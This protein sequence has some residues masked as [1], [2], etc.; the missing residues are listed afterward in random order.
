MSDTI[1]GYFLKILRFLRNYLTFSEFCGMMSLLR[2]KGE[3]IMNSRF[4]DEQIKVYAGCFGEEDAIYINNKWHEVLRGA[5]K[6]GRFYTYTN[7]NDYTINHTI[8][9][10]VNIFIGNPDGFY[11]KNTYGA[12]E[13]VI[14]NPYRVTTLEHYKL[15]GGE[16]IVWLGESDYFRTFGKMYQTNNDTNYQDDMGD[17]L[18][19]KSSLWGI[20]PRYEHVK[21]SKQINTNITLTLK[22]IEKLNQFNSV[23]HNSKH[24]VELLD[25]LGNHEQANELMQNLLSVK[26]VVDNVDKQR[27]QIAKELMRKE[28][29][30]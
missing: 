14:D 24:L 12:Y 19:V 25:S 10:G 11:F 8:D 9:T 16:K 29:N 20:I 28:C 27:N 4:T 21:D 1:E 17:L 22:D 15:Q 6:H 13:K 18:P 30:L 26:E 7:T 5:N 2:I 3:I 23:F